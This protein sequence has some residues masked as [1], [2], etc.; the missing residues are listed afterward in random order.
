MSKST[1][2]RKYILPHKVPLY[3]SFFHSD[4]S[5]QKF[6]RKSFKAPDRYERTSSY[7][8]DDPMDQSSKNMDD[9]DEVYDS[10][11]EF[12]EISGGAKKRIN[13]MEK[14]NQQVNVLPYTIKMC[15]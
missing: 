2:Y 15:S 14:I 5:P 4:D 10:I 11:T 9:F 1:A 3:F 6:E 13:K 12:E 8:D 7:V